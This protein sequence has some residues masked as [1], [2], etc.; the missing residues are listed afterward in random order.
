MN[1]IKKEII[2]GNTSKQHPVYLKKSV[3][4]V[5]AA[6]GVSVLW[7]FNDLSHWFAEERLLK[8][9]QRI[10]LFIVLQWSEMHYCCFCIHSL[11]CFSSTRHPFDVRFYVKWLNDTFEITW[12]SIQFTPLV[13]TLAPSSRQKEK[14]RE[15]EAGDSFGFASSFAIFVLFVFF[16]LFCCQK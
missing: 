5:L 9:M 3:Y 7:Q 6:V 12:T 2:N 8:L 11:N 13:A 16:F 15:G 10:D 4:G 1:V 14:K